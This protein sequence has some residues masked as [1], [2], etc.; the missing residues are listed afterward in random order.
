MFGLEDESLNNCPGLLT[1]GPKINI[2]RLNRYTNHASSQPGEPGCMRFLPA[3]SSVRRV[4]CKNELRCSTRL[5]FY[6][7]AGSLQV[8]RAFAPESQAP[9]SHVEPFVR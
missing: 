5:A 9:F 3:A 8:Q 1:V 7:E 6:C 2:I 4:A